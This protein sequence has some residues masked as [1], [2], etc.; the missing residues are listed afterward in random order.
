MLFVSYMPISP[1]FISVWIIGR[2]HSKK[3]KEIQI[4]RYESGILL[5][6]CIAVEQSFG[7]LN[8]VNDLNSQK[9]YLND[10]ALKCLYLFMISFSFNHFDTFLH[11]EVSRKEKLLWLSGIFSVFWY[12]CFSH[13]PF[14]TGRFH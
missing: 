13:P 10:D 4:W 7:C 3:A 8:L 11:S 6:V 5:I 12:R 9:G 2:F 1:G 14:S